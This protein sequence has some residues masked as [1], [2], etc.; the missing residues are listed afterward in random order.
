MG[1]S[2]S[3][4]SSSALSLCRFL[5]RNVSLAQSSSHGQQEEMVRG[6]REEGGETIS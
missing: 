2:G 6:S 1:S 4:S 3:G 5:R